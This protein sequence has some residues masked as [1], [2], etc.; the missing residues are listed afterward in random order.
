VAEKI[1]GGINGMTIR[2]LNGLAGALALTTALAAGEVVLAAAAPGGNQA[3][4]GDLSANRDSAEVTVSAQCSAPTNMT[5][6]KTGEVTVHIFQSVGRLL[7]I[8]IGHAPLTCDVNQAS[9]DVVVNAIPGLKFQPGPATL[10]VKVTEKTTT[11]SMGT[12][13]TTNTTTSETG[14]KVNLHP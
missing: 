4:D 5:D 7:N 8:G 1:K 3:A 2:K 13:T 9:I 6:T 14:S 10:I 11:N 12:M